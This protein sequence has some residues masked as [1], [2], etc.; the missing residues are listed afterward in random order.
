MDNNDV[1][2]SFIETQT[3][4]RTPALLDLHV[5][6]AAFR[7]HV[8]HVSNEEHG[9]SGGPGPGAYRK[10]HRHDVYHIVLYTRGVN[11]FLLND[12][13]REARPGVLALTGPGDSH[14]FGPYDG[15][16]VQYMELTFALRGEAGDLRIPFHELLG[17]YAGLDLPDLA[18]PVIL[19]PATMRTLSGRLA[20]LLTQ[21]MR[22]TP[23][24]W[25]AAFRT[26]LDLLALLADEVY[27]G[28]AESVR[29]ELA[30]LAAARQEID[31]RFAERLR[32]PE[33]AA[34]AHLS[35]G[36]FMRA[37]KAAFGLPPIAYQQEVRI[38][39]AQNLLRNTNLLCKEIAARIGFEDVYY[40]SKVFR[41]V[42]GETPSAFRRGGTDT[43][44]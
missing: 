38:R 5:S 40:F 29:A 43:L 14:S 30:P 12:I 20:L 42:T 24:A 9:R 3:P 11:R 31:E 8:L 41:K 33:L 2:R 44:V 18:M 27:A 15:G 25:F 4:A 7:F 39:A 6:G 17:R 28:P 36:Y 34:R 23:R 26:I 22:P 32:I 35:P 10:A 1:M 19:A 13:P 21:L 37:F 16:P